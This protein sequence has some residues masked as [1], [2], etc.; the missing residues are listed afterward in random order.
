[1]NNKNLKAFFLLLF[2][3]CYFLNAPSASSQWTESIGGN[4]ADYGQSITTDA[5]GNVYIIGNFRG[6]ADFDP[7]PDSFFLKSSCPC[8]ESDPLKPDIFFA[9]YKKT[10]ALVWARKVGG[11]R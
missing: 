4:N 9:K 1:M 8:D 3:A 6:K 10:G 2:T 7:G 11:R 5:N